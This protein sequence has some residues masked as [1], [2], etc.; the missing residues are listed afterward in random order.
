MQLKQ[1]N[2]YSDSQGQAQGDDAVQIG[3][4]STRIKLHGITTQLHSVSQMINTGLGGVQSSIKLSKRLLEAHALFC[5][6]AGR[7]KPGSMVGRTH[8][9]FRYV[10][11]SFLYQEHWLAQYRSRKETAMNFVCHPSST[12]LWASHLF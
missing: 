1:V 11:D 2:D 12:D 5:E 6:R 10:L 8:A 9:I 3:N 7:G 4:A